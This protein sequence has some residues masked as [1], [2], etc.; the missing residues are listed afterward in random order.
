MVLDVRASSDR[1]GSLIEEFE[2]TR[3][4]TRAEVLADELGDLG[5]PRRSDPCSGGSETLWC[6]K[7]AT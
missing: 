6:K 2:R 1:S 5:D 4:A 3:D 7:I